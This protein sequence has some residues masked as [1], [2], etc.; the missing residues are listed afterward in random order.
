MAQTA[1]RRPSIRLSQLTVWFQL[2]GIRDAN[3]LSGLRVSAIFNRLVAT[4]A[5]Y[6]LDVQAPTIAAALSSTASSSR[7]VVI[8]S[9]EPHEQRV[10]D[11]VRRDAQSARVKND[12]TPSGLSFREP[13]GAESA[14]TQRPGIDGQDAR[15]LQ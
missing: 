6:L 12:I 11:G 9:V 8:E 3:G 10:Q 2:A 4:D 13:P 7:L 14:A 1:S 15:H 5:L